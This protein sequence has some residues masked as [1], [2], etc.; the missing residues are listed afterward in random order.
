MCGCQKAKTGETYVWQVECK[1]DGEK[2]PYL[3][4]IEAKAAVAVCKG[5]GTYT[6]VRQL[7]KAA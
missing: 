6:R 3:T 7:T 5:S 4:E 1:S 2:R